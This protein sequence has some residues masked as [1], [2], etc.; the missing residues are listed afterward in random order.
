MTT[1]SLTGVIL[2]LESI[3]YIVLCIV[4]LGK[5]GL[6]DRGARALALYALVSGL[7]IGEQLAGHEGWLDY[8]HGDVYVLVRISSYG[9]VL[10][11]MLLLGLTRAFLRLTGSGWRWL[12]LGVLWIG[13]L[14]L[15][16]SSVLVL[17]DILWLPN[18]WGISRM[19][20]TFGLAVGGWALFMMAAMVLTVR[21]VRRT[22]L[23]LHRNR[24]TY[25]LGAWAFTVAG[26][27]FFAGGYQIIGSD[28]R[29]LGTVVAAY[30]VLTHRL[31]DVR[32]TTR[33]L[34]SYLI[35][36]MLTI[37]IYTAGVIAV[38]YFFENVPGY[39]PLWAGAA[40]ALVLAI[41]F[42]P[43][44]RLVQKLVSRII[45]GT[46]YDPGHI[47]REYSLRISN[48][49]SLK[50]LGILVVDFINEALKIEHGIL[51]TIHHERDQEGHGFY[52]LR[53]IHGA[54]DEEPALGSLSDTSPLT[55]HLREGH[56][57]LTQYDVDLLPA[58]KEA[59]AEER[60]L[61]A[62][63]NMD[64][65][66]PIL[67]QGSWI[68]LLALGS[69]IS[70]DRYFDEDLALLST[71]ADQTAVALENA[72]L[73]DD[74]IEI[75][76]DLEEA[77]AELE[78]ANRQLQEMDRLKSAFIGVIT[79]ELRSPF[80]NIAFSLQLFQRHGLENLTAEQREQL[81]QLLSNL[82][83]AK[84]MIDNLVTFATFL[85]KQG[86]LH[87]STIDFR[88][89]LHD[90]LLPLKPLIEHK[91]LKF[92]T[93]LS[94]ELPPVHGD[95]ERLVD[96]VHHLVHNA[97]KFTMPGGEIW[98]RCQAAEGKLFFEVKDT[99]VG[100]PANR[101]SSLWEEFAQMADPLQRGVE[102]LGLGLT[103]VKYVVNAHGGQVWAESEE[104]V[105]SKFG[106][107]I[108]LAGPGSA[109]APVP[110]PAKL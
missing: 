84:S 106:F 35:I 81:E 105:G 7:W 11:A 87:L 47:V 2:M 48:V 45:T 107:E 3:L 26:D 70:G 10:L 16:D 104:G 51:F 91:S 1:Q 42:D 29:L 101:L 80:A 9:L 28:V 5:G 6:R 74:L 55:N 79:H 75:N 19:A 30:V 59:P 72:R 83:Q 58:F 67:A 92:R 33:R 17:P 49:V 36:T 27:L 56:H 109:R 103:L 15:L 108:P 41:L 82:Q 95:R 32:K 37:I 57:P 53:G 62:S 20:L 40:V 24:I 14:V 18:G 34:L 94:P 54:A 50:R 77:Y 99:G 78:R 69:K 44:L 52:R 76:H 25:W 23:P 39:D 63:L 93:V 97:Y 85:S 110:A 89:I 90:A 12:A 31:P 4:A 65:Y 8:L 88:Q 96:A 100:I 73:V 46:S 102:G 22:H 71:L 38:R 60:A 68:G 13:V 86:D 66:V 43:L 98:V 61:L 21:T 64:V